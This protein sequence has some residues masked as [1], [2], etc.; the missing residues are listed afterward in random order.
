MGLRSSIGNAILGLRGTMGKTQ[1]E[2]A[3]DSGISRTDFAKIEKGI[4]TPSISTL[5]NIAQGLGVSLIELLEKVDYEGIRNY[6]NPENVIEKTLKVEIAPSEFLYFRG[7]KSLL[8][9]PLRVTI[10]GKKNPTEF[11]I[12]R[13]EQITEGFV[14]K[15]YVIVSGLEKGIDTIAQQTCLKNNGKAIAVIPS[16]LRNILPKENRG[17]AE[18]IIK[19]GGLLLS[20]Y[21]EN[22]SSRPPYYLESRK[23]QV[24][25]GIGVIIVES[26]LKGTEMEVGL[27]ALK[28]KK[29]LSCVDTPEE[30]WSRA[31]GNIILIK[32]HR[33]K[34][35]VLSD[36]RFTE[37]E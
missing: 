6:T 25:L 12:M 9:H 17:L 11:G 10:I 3:N 34:I 26:Q 1:E 37:I 8:K 15:G 31:K 5:L 27:Y 33:D 20:K 7:D 28:Q 23:V 19:A 14:E 18:K 13:C 21:P 4:T 2:V 29:K 36:D 32:E 35:I 16:G 24:N 30:Y 22:S